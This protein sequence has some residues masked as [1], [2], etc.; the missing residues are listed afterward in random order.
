M[1]SICY[2][3]GN[4]LFKGA[5][6]CNICGSKIDT[7]TTDKNELQP[8]H[9][10]YSITLSETFRKFWICTIE[11][12]CSLTELWVS[13]FL[14]SGFI[15]ILCLITYLFEIVFK[16]SY[17]LTF[18]IALILSTSASV[19]GIHLIC[20]RLHD[21]NISSC[22]LFIVGIPIINI[23]FLLY[24]LFTP[25]DDGKND[26]GPPTG[27]C[28]KNLRLFENYSNEE[29]NITFSNNE[30]LPEPTDEKDDYYIKKH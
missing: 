21:L 25:G 11:G 29:K 13:F 17:P 16:C 4:P 28:L 26:Y 19:A 15:I 10:D 12:R 24:T 6:V 20:R 8:V 27:Y 3:C 1:K 2:K 22:W 7:Q 18:I 23:L 5:K 9:L 30:E 14:I